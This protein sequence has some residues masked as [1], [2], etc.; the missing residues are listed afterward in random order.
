MRERLPLCP[1]PFQMAKKKTSREPIPLA[2]YIPAETKIDNVIPAIVPVN[3]VYSPQLNFYEWISLQGLQIT[4][5]KQCGA[6]TAEIIY[7]V[8]TG[9]CLYLTGATLDFYSINVADIGAV[10]GQI[11]IS[12]LVVGSELIEI[13]TNSLPQNSH[14]IT[15]DF[16]IPLLISEKKI[17]YINCSNLL[18]G[19]SATI[20]GFLVPNDLKFN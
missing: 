20:Y 3:K 2:G 17:F 1:V 14:Q 12:P 5:T 9:Y 10:S 4:K 7:T 16:T 6:A 13:R 18:T 15:K 19:G 8:P 11:Y